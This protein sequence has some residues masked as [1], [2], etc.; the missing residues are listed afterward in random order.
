MLGTP[1][2]LGRTARRRPPRPAPGGPTRP[3]PVA[4]KSV[5]ATGMG[6]ILA[7]S[8]PQYNRP[9]TAVLWPKRKYNDYW[10]MPWPLFLPPAIAVGS[11]SPELAGLPHLA[12]RENGQRGTMKR[13]SGQAE[14][15]C[16]KANASEAHAPR[17]PTGRG[18][19]AHGSRWPY[20]F[21]SCRPT[22]S[23]NYLFLLIITYYNLLII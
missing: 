8:W 1:V 15:D 13:P 18:R 23:R 22:R 16:P 14:L 9:S 4:G 7:N 2:L 10:R 11:W 19:S 17:F 20:W 6:T 5:P 21:T 3:I 12:S